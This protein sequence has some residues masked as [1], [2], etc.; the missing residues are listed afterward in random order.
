MRRKPLK[1]TGL[2]ATFLLLVLIWSNSTWGQKQGNIWYFGDYAAVDFN[3]GSPVGLN[4]SAMDSYEAVATLSDS[5]GNLLFYTN[6]EIIWDRTHQVM[7][8]G[9][10][11]MG[12]FTSTQC[13]IVPQPGNDSLVY[14]FSTNLF[15]YHGV[16]YSI[17]NLNG[18]SGLGE[19][20]SKNNLLVAPT[21]E[22]V[23]FAQHS[24]GVDKW[25]L[26]KPGGYTHEYYAYLLSCQG[27]DTIPVI[28]SFGN[29]NTYSFGGYLK[30]SP[31][32][33]LVANINQFQDTLEIFDFDPSTGLLSNPLLIQL[34]TSLQP[35]GVAFSPDETKVYVGYG[36]HDTLV[37]FGISSGNPAIITAS[38]ISTK[39]PSANPNYGWVGGMTLG[40]DG[41][42]YLVS[43]GR[44]Y[45]SAIYQ[46]N[47]PCPA[48][49]Y[50]EAAV[51]L[52][53]GVGQAGLPHDYHFLRPNQTS[54]GLDSLTY[55]IGDTLRFEDQSNYQADLSIWTFGDPAS[56]PLDTVVSP[57]PYHV[58]HSPGTYLVTLHNEHGCLIDSA[59]IVVTIEEFSLLNLGQDTTLCEAG[60]LLL[61][62]PNQNGLI[63]STGDTTSS[64]YI[65]SPG[66]VW[67][68][69]DT[70]G[71]TVRDSFHLD[72]LLLDSIYLGPD[73][74]FCDLPSFS[75]SIPMVADQQVWSNGDTTTDINVNYSGLYWV[76]V[77][78]DDCI[79]RDSIVLGF[80]DSPEPDLGPDI[81]LCQGDTLLLNPG[82]AATFSWSTGDT[83]DQLPVTLPG[84]YT[85]LA[86][87]QGCWGTDSIMVSLTPLLQ[88]D[89]GPDTVLCGA[90][91]LFLSN[92]NQPATTLW[93]TGDTLPEIIV[94][95]PGIY[96]LTLIGTCEAVIDEIQIG[97]DIAPEI[98]LADSF[99]LCPGERVELNAPGTGNTNQWFIRYPN[100]D[101]LLSD[102]QQVI[103]TVPGTYRL[104]VQNSCGLASHDFVLQKEP[105]EEVFIPN[106]FTPNGDFLQDE[107]R[108]ETNHPERYS[109]LIHDRWGKL[110]YESDNPLDG[111]DGNCKGKPVVEGVYFYI[112]TGG[113]R[114]EPVKQTGTV[115]LI[116]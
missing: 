70:A 90:E 82:P 37:Q 6:G 72:Y 15:L 103:L 59:S 85:V 50:V 65:D 51:P 115:T 73:T 11:L 80:E 63:W 4:N 89:L 88:V 42:L 36:N 99:R 22:K 91:T 35:Y 23:A 16:R 71:C 10:G 56:G 8:N 41:V 107:F 95:E 106:V 78:S 46:P 105:R 68:E 44:P 26:C 114:G 14:V 19:V 76:E 67:V 110:V 113:C 12:A 79:L 94:S 97:R 52:P 32:E 62:V 1:Q 30:F 25:V 58:Y 5:A 75:L 54:I 100:G 108:P 60:G 21:Q 84:E 13:G 27:L 28:S 45:L 33:K 24:N 9:S 39:I 77:S 3:S 116:R 86:Y 74:Q 55:C 43:F 20:V 17:V 40:P 93:S 61:Q 7:L 87:N 31:S 96:S 66:W 53:T 109:I 104:E 64:V 57:D 69:V 102:Q 49:Q 2:F 29:T 38:K 83:T 48:C 111:W 18:N 47:D 92:N 101:E 81:T 34:E 112:L 98:S